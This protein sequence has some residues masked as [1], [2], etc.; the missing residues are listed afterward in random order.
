M[1]DKIYSFQSIS[2]PM[3]LHILAAVAKVTR[4]VTECQVLDPMGKSG[5]LI[6]F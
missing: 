4:G 6:N 3:C 5:C 2:G 1:F